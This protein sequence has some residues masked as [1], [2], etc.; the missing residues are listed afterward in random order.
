MNP[1]PQRVEAIF[2]AAVELRSA[3]EREAFLTSACGGDSNLRHRVEAL[4][5]AHAAA[6]SFLEHLVEPVQGMETISVTG[7]DAPRPGTMV[8]YFGDYELLDEIARGGMG[9]VYRATQVSLKREV[10]LKLILSG[11]LAGPADVRR[12]RTEAEA[13]AQLDHPNILPIH[14]VGEHD[15]QQYFSMKLI[16]GGSL[17]DAIAARR[18]TERE[19]IAL[20]IKVARAVH[21]AHQRGILHRDLKPANILLDRDQTP[22]VSDFGLAKRVESDSVLTQTGAILGSP[23]YMPPEQARGE[24]TYDRDR[25]V[26]IGRDSLPVPHGPAAVSGGHG[27]RH[28]Y[29]S[30]RARASTSEVSKSDSRSRS[31][32]DRD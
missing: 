8:R 13:A 17:A 19:A 1:D 29:A 21:F 26:C 20:L 28:D 31:F 22:Y 3:E 16:D 2:A 10:A 27:S 11:Q 9:V 15:G 7:Q 6:G 30:A 23:S 12:F 32:D 5:N 25:R 4:L 24:A 18:L 14:E